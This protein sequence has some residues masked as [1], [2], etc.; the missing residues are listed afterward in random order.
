MIGL[1]RSAF[2]AASR[3]MMG[4]MVCIQ[5][6]RNGGLSLVRSMSSRGRRDNCLGARGKHLPCE[7]A[8]VGFLS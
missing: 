6:L 7:E 4:P 2:E 8:C 1:G 5:W 3:T